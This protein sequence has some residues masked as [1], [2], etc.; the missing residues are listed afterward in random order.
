MSTILTIVLIAVTTI[1]AILMTVSSIL[2]SFLSIFHMYHLRNTGSSQNVLIL[3][4][5]EPLTVLAAPFV[6]YHSIEKNAI[7]KRKEKRQL[8]Y[9]KY[10]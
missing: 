2:S 1:P 3:A 7:T 9:Y 10:I 5:G 8:K 6:L 4:K